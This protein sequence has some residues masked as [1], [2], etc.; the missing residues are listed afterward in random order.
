MTSLRLRTI[1]AGACGAL[2]T[3]SVAQAQTVGFAASNPGSLYHSS[4]SAISK[5]ANDKA[6]IKLTVQPFASATVY[7]PAVDAGEFAFGLSNV[8]ELRVAVVGEKQFEGRKYGDL[9]A[10]AITYPL[11]VAFFVKNDSDI[12]TVADLKGKRVTDGYASQKTIPPLLD[13]LY[14]SA[15][16]TRADIKPVPVSNVVGGANAFIQGKADAFFFALGAAKVREADASVGGIR[17]LGI[18]DSPENRAIAAKHF[19]PAYLRTEKPSKPNVGVIAPI[20]VITYDAVVV[21][22]TKT[23]E[24]VVY[25]LVKA[26]HD[27]KKDMAAVFPIFNLFNPDR[28]ASDLGP[29]QWHPGTVKYLTEQGMWPPK[30]N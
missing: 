3:V 11:R 9:R 18:E 19:P 13:A 23:S 5:M 22:S 29:I 7:L 4:A 24:D 1:I 2:L 8:E 30:A 16:M 17:A 6:D 27:N 26:M 20:N 12:K 15:G 10:V 21:S 25:R 14:A 28:M